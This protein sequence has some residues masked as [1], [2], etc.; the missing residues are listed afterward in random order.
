M[1]KEKAELSIEEE[2]RQDMKL[3]NDPFIRAVEMSRAGLYIGPSL[4]L[5]ETFHNIGSGV[6]DQQVED[7]E[8]EGPGGEKNQK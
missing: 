5:G 8:N 2:A 4:S 6:T 1:A 7:F 3:L